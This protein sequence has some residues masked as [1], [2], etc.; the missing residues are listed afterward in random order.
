MRVYV[1]RYTPLSRRE[2]IDIQERLV[3]ILCATSPATSE[4]LPCRRRSRRLSVKPCW[5]GV[6]VNLVR[7]LL[8]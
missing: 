5:W 1:R 8:I 7:I 4:V 2:W 6:V 3:C